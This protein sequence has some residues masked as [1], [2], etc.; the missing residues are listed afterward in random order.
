MHDSCPGF[1]KTA[2]CQHLGQL[3]GRTERWQLSD[4]RCRLAANKTRR[5]LIGFAVPGRTAFRT[6]PE[7][8]LVVSGAPD[9]CSDSNTTV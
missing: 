9:L 5:D 8:A 4:T 1:S 7:L 3:V 2:V 6:V